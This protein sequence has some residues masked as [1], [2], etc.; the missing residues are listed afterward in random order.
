MQDNSLLSI[1]ETF[2]ENVSFSIFKNESQETRS[3]NCFSLK[4]TE[5]INQNV[6]SALR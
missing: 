4:L 1:T 6:T 2:E 5:W 3:N